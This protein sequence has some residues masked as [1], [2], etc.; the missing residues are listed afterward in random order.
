MFRLLPDT[1]VTW[2]DVWGGALLTALLFSLGKHLFGLYLGH[3]GVTS[4]FGAAAS[5]VVVLI[6]VYYSSL[7]LLF[8]AEVTHSYATMVGSRR[9]ATAVEEPRPGKGGRAAEGRE[10]TTAARS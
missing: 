5:L 4:G 6:W 7:L 3:V 1:D 8:G 2:G 10:L 9:G